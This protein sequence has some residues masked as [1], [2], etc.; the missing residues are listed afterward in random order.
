MNI[1]F[2][3]YL[4]GNGVSELMVYMLLALPF[5][6]LLVS[7]IRQFIGIKAFSIYE[8]LV[9]S[10]SLFFLAPDFATGLK[11]GIP[12][13]ALAWGVSELT[14]RLLDQTRLHYISKVSI[15]IS[16]ASLA[17]LAALS[18][19]A[20]FRKAGFY[21]INMLAVI[22]ILTMIESVN[23][24]RVKKGDVAAN[25][26]SLETLLITFLCYSLLSFKPFEELLLER[27]YLVVLAIVGEIFVGR[28]KGLRLSEYIRFRDIFKND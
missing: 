2:S 26:I 11:Y 12:I 6:A 27:S 25:I 21:S 9:L 18:F 13:I 19:A 28:W 10:Y 15:K 1:N 5:V 14:R 24:F 4:I 22:I 17:M 3:D 20:Y 8:P 23:L 16:L 7:F